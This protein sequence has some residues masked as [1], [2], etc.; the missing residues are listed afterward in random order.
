MHCFN[1][2]PENE[3]GDWRVGAVAFVAAALLLALAWWMSGGTK[4]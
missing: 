4:W 1:D 3:P 2:Q